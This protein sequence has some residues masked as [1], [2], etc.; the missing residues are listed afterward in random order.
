MFKA[1]SS[2]RRAEI[3]DV[4]GRYAALLGHQQGHYAERGTAI[5]GGEESG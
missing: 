3:S 5:P 4:A 1:N 2:G